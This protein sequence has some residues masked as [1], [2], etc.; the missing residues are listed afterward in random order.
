M[1]RLLQK[2]EKKNKI[3]RLYYY[4][5]F[6]KVKLKYGILDFSVKNGKHIYQ[7]SPILK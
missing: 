5:K 3:D 6:Q 2:E 7:R 4:L 1:K